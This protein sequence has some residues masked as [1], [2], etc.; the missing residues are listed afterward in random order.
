MSEHVEG[1]VKPH[2]RVC[3]SWRMAHENWAASAGTLS[4]KEL[5][6]RSSM[7]R[8][9]ASRR[10]IFVRELRQWVSKGVSK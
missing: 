10:A 5:R 2:P 4:R 7:V 9:V 3:L 1:D 6:V 8:R